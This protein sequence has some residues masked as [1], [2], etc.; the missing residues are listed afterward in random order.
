MA[1]DYQA[2][3]DKILFGIKTCIEANSKYT[4]VYNDKDYHGKEYIELVSENVETGELYAGS[5][6]YSTSVAVKF[7]TNKKD[8]KLIKY[9][10][11][12]IMDILTQNNYYKISGVHYY[13]N[14]QIL[15]TEFIRQQDIDAEVDDPYNFKITYAASHTKVY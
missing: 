10:M 3:E 7:Y 6:T 2:V 1:L 8:N 12:V 11:E 4:V 15:G 14:G 13:F 5:S 9:D